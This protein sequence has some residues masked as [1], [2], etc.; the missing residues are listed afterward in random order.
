M[1]SYR[2]KIAFSLPQVYLASTL[3]DSIGFLATVYY[4]EV[5]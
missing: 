1:T 5:M 3:G 2:S 4:T